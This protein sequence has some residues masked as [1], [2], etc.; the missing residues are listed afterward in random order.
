VGTWRLFVNRECRWA[1]AD[2]YAHRD[3]RERRQWREEHHHQQQKQEIANLK[4][5]SHKS[6]IL[7]AMPSSATVAGTKAIM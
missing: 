6:I 1:N 2:G 4:E 3:L 7:P 5:V